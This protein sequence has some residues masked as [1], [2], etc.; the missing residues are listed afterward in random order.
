MTSADTQCTATY[1]PWNNIIIR[2]A[3][4]YHGHDDAL[5][6]THILNGLPAPAVTL[7]KLVPLDL[8]GPLVK[9]VPPV[10]KALSAA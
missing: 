6:Q 10:H 7:L 2:T 9:L 4:P 1:S 3:P 8:R 5:W